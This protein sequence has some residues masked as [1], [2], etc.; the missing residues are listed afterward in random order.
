MGGHSIIRHR[1]VHGR[2]QHPSNYGHA[3]YCMPYAHILLYALCMPTFFMCLLLLLLICLP[4]YQ[5]TRI[6][7][8]ML[9]LTAR[10]NPAE[11]SGIG[12]GTSHNLSYSYCPVMNS[13]APQP[14]STAYEEHEGMGGAWGHSGVPYTP[15]QA[16]W[17]IAPVALYTNSLSFMP[18]DDHSTLPSH[19]HYAVP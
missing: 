19:A 7:L 11:K 13:V 3:A 1:T 17:R 2:A 15:T 4:L 9:K 18:Y 10:D 5:D 14:E 12:K 8:M 16:G 6:V